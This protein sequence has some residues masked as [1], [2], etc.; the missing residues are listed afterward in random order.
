MTTCVCVCVVIY[1]DVRERN[2]AFYAGLA[3]QAV[4]TEMSDISEADPVEMAKSLD[5]S[6]SSWGPS[7][8]DHI[9][10]HYYPCCV[11]NAPSK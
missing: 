9:S 10:V 7:R 4:D 8:Q 3:A 5:V 2:D 11:F 1:G 6:A